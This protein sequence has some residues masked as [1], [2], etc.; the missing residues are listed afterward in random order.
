MHARALEVRPEGLE[1][2][3]PDAH[4]EQRIE[5][6]ELIVKDGQPAVGAADI[7]CEDHGRDHKR[8]FG[9]VEGRGISAED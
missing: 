1:A 3:S 6:V 5:A 2:R 4:A 9:A 8:R 7:A